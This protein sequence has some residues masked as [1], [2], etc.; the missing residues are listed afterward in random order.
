MKQMTTMDVTGATGARE[1]L[2]ALGRFGGYFTESLRD[3]YGFL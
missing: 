3:V 2:T 1:E